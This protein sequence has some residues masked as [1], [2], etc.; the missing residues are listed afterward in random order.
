MSPAAAIV[1]LAAFLA[2]NKLHDPARRGLRAALMLSPANKALLKANMAHAL[3]QRDVSALRFSYRALLELDPSDHETRTSAAI[4][5]LLSGEIEHARS[6]LAPA[7]GWTRR[8][9]LGCGLFDRH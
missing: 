9:A 1:R 4:S 7:Q 8:T 5:E 2:R 3:V 6:L